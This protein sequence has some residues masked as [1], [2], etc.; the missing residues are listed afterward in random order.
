MGTVLLSE[1]CAILA[2]RIWINIIHTIVLYQNTIVSI[3]IRI[4]YHSLY[5]S[6]CTMIVTFVVTPI[7]TFIYI[8]FQIDGLCSPVS[9]RNTDANDLCP[10]HSH[11]LHIAVNENVLIHLVAIESI[12]EI[13]NNLTW[14]IHTN[15]VESPTSILLL[16]VFIHPKQNQPAYGIGKSRIRLSYRFWHLSLSFLAFQR[17]SLTFQQCLFYSFFVHIHITLFSLILLSNQNNQESPFIS[18]TY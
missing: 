16:Q 3:C 17:Y 15:Y 8:V 4:T 7:R 11:H 1:L 12:P 9:L 2:Q 14:F 6:L 18:S 5:L 13:C 10:I